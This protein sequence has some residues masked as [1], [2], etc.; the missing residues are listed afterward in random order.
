[1]T[2]DEPAIGFRIWAVD[3]NIYG[4]VELPTIVEWVKDERVTSGTWVFSDHDDAWRKAAE[5]PELRMFF[6]KR[7]ATPAAAGGVTPGMLRRVKALGD[8]TDEQLLRFIDFM[9]TQRVGGFVQV[10]RQGDHGDSMFL[11]LEGE[12]RVRLMVDGRET[13]LVTLGPGDFFGEI[14]L[15]DQGPR[16]ADVIANV[17]SVLI[18]VGHTAFENFVK[19]AP[20]AAAPFLMAISKTLTAR[21]RA[22][23]K[24]Y[25]DSIA[26]ARASQ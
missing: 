24:R 3:N 16:S 22:D 10:C 4:P 21:I 8:L 2:G 13:T 7:I 18:K 14:A 20:E 6:S 23:N 9:E 19:T 15:F 26:F 11:V 12:L 25:R 1:M 17:D 5:V